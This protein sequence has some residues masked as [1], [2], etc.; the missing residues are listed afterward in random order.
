MAHFGPLSILREEVE[1]EGGNGA[2]MLL[3][4][5]LATNVGRS[6]TTYLITFLPGLPPGFSFFVY[7]CI[8]TVR[9]I[10]LNYPLSIISQR[11][12]AH[13]VVAVI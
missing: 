9:K 1:R 7:L 3:R 12:Q 2:F 4:V 11:Q 6:N 13:L 8:G 5:I 10:L